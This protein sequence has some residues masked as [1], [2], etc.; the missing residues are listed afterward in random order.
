MQ[1]LPFRFGVRAK[2]FLASVSVIVISVVVAHAYLSSSL[3]RMLTDGI[4][5]D[6]FVRLALVEREAEP[7]EPS[8]PTAT[9]DGLADD[10]GARAG[11]RVTF[12]ASDGRVLGD[13]EVALDRLPAVEN[14][15]SRPEVQEAMKSG[16]GSAT[17]LSDT[18]QKRLLYVAEPM[19]K[20]GFARVAL[21]LV[22]V[23]RAE[24][25]LRQALLM[26]TLLALALATLI[27]FFT[28]QLN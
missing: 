15:L 3:D 6:L 28:T 1:R 11:A 18:I 17:R 27:S 22:E 12:I 14:H 23:E 13:S 21:P 7:I 9:W 20:G 25:Q 10:L 19:K 2:L 24:A 5:D 16:H 8:A 26:G 4:R